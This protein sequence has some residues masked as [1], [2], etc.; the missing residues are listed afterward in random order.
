LHQEKQIIGFSTIKRK[1][2][3]NTTQVV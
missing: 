3:D 1:N 2:L